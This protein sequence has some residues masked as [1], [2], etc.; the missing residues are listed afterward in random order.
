MADKGKSSK[1]SLASEV[2]WTGK[3]DRKALNS[4]HSWAPTRIQMASGEGKPKAPPAVPPASAQPAA[5]P[6]SPPKPAA[7]KPTPPKPAAAPARP[8]PPPAPPAAKPVPPP[9]KP[10]V[11]PAPKPAAAPAPKPAAPPPPR[12]APAAA[13][14]PAAPAPAAPRPAPVAARPAPAP[15]APMGRLPSPQEQSERL[16]KTV[17]G[18]FVERIKQEAGRKGGTLTLEDI[19]A[20]DEEFAQRTVAL[21]TAFEKTFD[22]YIRAARADETWLPREDPL[23]RLVVSAFDHLLAD[24]TQ[25]GKPGALSRRLLPGFFMAMGLMMGPDAVE[26]F[27]RR[28]KTIVS[29]NRLLN[30]EA[31]TWA[32]VLEDPEAASLR[33]EALVAIA[34]HFA[35]PDKRA[36]WFVDMVNNYLPEASEGAADAGWRLSRPAYERLIDALFTP[37]M[38]AITGQANRESFARQFGHETLSAVSDIMRGLG[39]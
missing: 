32:R 31:K 34:V 12:P 21:Q 1:D 13:P 39:A 4:E 14:R 29:R 9:P 6:A 5:R 26:S 20:L 11:A 18:T 2:V 24:E 17:V 30:D 15:K 16:A 27:E 10:A 38:K 35:N 28:A 23:R 19:A 36:A 37:V 8:A 3:S 7:P 33:L 22:E 25:A